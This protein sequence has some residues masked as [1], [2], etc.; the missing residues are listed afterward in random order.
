MT[1][2]LRDAQNRTVVDLDFTKD[3]F[4]VVVCI[5]TYSEK[6]FE[7]T[8]PMERL[9]FVRDMEGI[10]ELRGEWWERALPFGKES[11][12]VFAERR[13]REVG[14]KWNLAFVTD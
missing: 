10:Q 8:L 3:D 1:Y 5:G 4:H 7:L 12:Y 13:M 14:K 11:I 6:L 2:F 9:A